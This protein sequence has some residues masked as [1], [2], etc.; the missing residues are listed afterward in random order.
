MCGQRLSE[1]RMRKERYVSYKLFIYIQHMSFAYEAPG[2][3]SR[4]GEA[5][6]WCCKG[7]QPGRINYHS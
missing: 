2:A 5:L 7:L 6:V 1:R 3:T 4:P